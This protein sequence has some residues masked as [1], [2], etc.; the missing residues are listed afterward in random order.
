MPD[1]VQ[2]RFAVYMTACYGAN[3]E[4]RLP[5]GQREES[6]QHFFM[7]ALTYQDLILNILEPTAGPLSAAEEAR[8]D[9]LMAEINAE[10]DAFGKK[11]I[12]DLF[13]AAGVGGGRA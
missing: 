2:Q 8:G 4:T 5:E 3:W 1:H 11:R 6:R 13:I 12:F 7:G 9:L 10:I